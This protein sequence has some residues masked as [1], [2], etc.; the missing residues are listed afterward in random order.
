MTVQPT[1][2]WFSQPHRGVVEE[3]IT[4]GGRGRVKYEATSWPAELAPSAKDASLPPKA[5]VLVVGRT[6]LVL[7]VMPAE[8]A[9]QGS[10]VANSS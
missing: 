6:G 10:A 3:T 8:V 2:H 5:A 9:V 1:T 7:L 4:Q